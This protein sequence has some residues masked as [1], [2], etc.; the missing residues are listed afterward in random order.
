MAVR[1]P[2]WI[3]PDGGEDQYGDDL[4]SGTPV[5]VPGAIVLPRK[6]T[7][8]AQ[9]GMI[10]ISGYEVILKPPPA[11][12]VI[13]ASDSI[14]IRGTEQQIEGEPGLYARKALQFFTRKVGTGG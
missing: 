3:V 10:V 8:S 14:L 1:E 7:E 11:D 9:G 12:L 2:I 13:S 5:Y 6:S 4:P